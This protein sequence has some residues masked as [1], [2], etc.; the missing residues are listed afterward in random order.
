[1]SAEAR[2]SPDPTLD[3][4]IIPATDQALAIW[5]ALERLDRLLMG[6]SHPHT[7]PTLQVPPAQ[8]AIAAAT[9]QLRSARTPG[10]RLQTAFGSLKVYRRSPLRASQTKSS[11]L[12]PVLAT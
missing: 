6:L 10:Q 11:P 2:R 5:A 4:A 8:H 7:L 9:Q 3:R 1:M 12:P